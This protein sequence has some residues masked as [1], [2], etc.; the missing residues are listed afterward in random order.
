MAKISPEMQEEMAR[1]RG[2]GLSLQ[3]VAVKINEKFG[4]NI[5]HQTVSYQLQKR[6]E[7]TLNHNK[8]IRIINYQQI[9][10]TSNKVNLSNHEFEKNRNSDLVYQKGRDVHEIR[11]D[12]VHSTTMILPNNTNDQSYS[13]WNE[14][15]SR[16]I[17]VAML[18][19]YYSIK[20][21]IDQRLNRLNEEKI[22]Q[23]LS[24]FGLRT[25]QN[26]VGGRFNQNIFKN[27]QF[28][29]KVKSL[30]LEIITDEYS[31][32]ELQGNEQEQLISLSMR[33][34]SS[35]E[36]SA[37][38]EKNIEDN[39]LSKVF[40]IA[41]FDVFNSLGIP[42]KWKDLSLETGCL[43]TGKLN[44][45]KIG[46]F[47]DWSEF[48]IA[49]EAGFKMAGDWVEAKNKNCKSHDDYLVVTE[50]GWNTFEELEHARSFG[51]PDAN[52]HHYYELR[53]HRKLEQS[54]VDE[55]N[56][57]LEN[58]NLGHVIS[59]GNGKEI[60][61]WKKICNDHFQSSV[62]IIPK[63]I[64]AYNQSQSSGRNITNEEQLKQILTKSPFSKHCTIKIEAGIVE[65]NLDRQTSETN[66]QSKAIDDDNNE[67]ENVRLTPVSENDKRKLPFDISGMNFLL[68]SNS[69][70]A[71]KMIRRLESND[72]EDSIDEAWKWVAF[73]APGEI[74]AC[75][76]RR[77]EKICEAIIEKLNLRNH[78]KNQLHTLRML[79]NDIQHP[80][81]KKCKD[82]PEWKYVQ[83][84]LE[85]V[86]RLIIVDGASEKRS[87]RPTNPFAKN[88]EA[89]EIYRLKMEEDKELKRLKMEIDAI[90]K[91]FETQSLGVKRQK[92]LMR[93]LK[94]IN[95]EINK[96]LE[97]LKKISAS[98]AKE[99]HDSVVNYLGREPEEGEILPEC[100]SCERL[101]HPEEMVEV[102]DWCGHEF[103]EDEK[104]YF[105]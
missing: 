87:K 76:T 4:L 85:I 46:K 61:L 66:Y 99:T 36:L 38:L 51:I 13:S 45:F 60:D 48:E 39:H 1:L 62:V 89:K 88:K 82:K 56:F 35:S 5:T 70:E 81:S 31:I 47:D 72:L 59:F 7:N 55:L 32:E 17:D 20:K 28:S 79:R 27:L 86:E 11:S 23:L 83:F 42:E 9:Q 75:D 25:I 3:E 91:L 73:N 97:Y 102:C 50:N 92:G 52:S 103:T 21:N 6:K 104:D 44:V 33:F 26:N 16:D 90:T 40:S 10:L 12:C 29:E 2:S 98:Q 74:D 57:D 105:S 8:P 15:Y 58:D 49:F 95:A 65:I 77:N 24:R 19:Y 69:T 94:D 78:E 84:G 64:E 101:L 80:E 41:F 37:S 53:D 63:L 100:P 43:D 34:K 22:E 68:E 71:S 96:R 30:F 93:K 14:V 67:L 54:F 18:D